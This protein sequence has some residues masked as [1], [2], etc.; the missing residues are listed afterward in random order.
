MKFVITS[1]SIH[2]TKLY[3][4]FTLLSVGDQTRGGALIGI[5]P[6]RENEITNLSHWIDT[7]AYLKPH[8]DGLLLT[9]NVAKSLGAQ[10]GDTLVLISQGYHGASA[11]GLFPVKGIIRFASPQLNNLGAYIDI[12]R[13]REFFSAYDRATSVVILL[14]NQDLTNEV[15]SQIAQTLGSRFSVKSWNEIQPEIQQMIDADRSGG[16]VMKVILY[17]IIA[18]GIFGT[19]IMMVSE[20]KRELGVMV[21]VGMRKGRLATIVITSYSIHYTK[22]YDLFEGLKTHKSGLQ[23]F[24]FPFACG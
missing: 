2:Y 14:E 22:L 7:G 10:L 3:E 15:H 1:Y 12:T 8:D 20:R 17:L 23:A 16:V 11:A 4:S 19:V 21:A 6:V 18:F 5:D 9:S 13:A 24:D